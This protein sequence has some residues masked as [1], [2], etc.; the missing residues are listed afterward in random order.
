MIVCELVRYNV[1]IA[2]GGDNYTAIW[3]MVFK[4]HESA[5]AVSV[6]RLVPL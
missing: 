4:L 2:C 5:R 6:C 1:V 3:Y